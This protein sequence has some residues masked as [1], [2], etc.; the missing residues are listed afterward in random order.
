MRRLSLSFALVLLAPAAAAQVNYDTVQI[1]TVK[2][3]EGVYMLMGSG[4]NIGVSVG[5]DGV[6]LVDDQFA[7]L[8]DK[9][10][11]AIAALGSPIRFL[12]NTH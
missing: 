11:A 2:A 6:I 10:K 9:I 1:R 8:S 4:G 3:A 7:P 12:L 5:G